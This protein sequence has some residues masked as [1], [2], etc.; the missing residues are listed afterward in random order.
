MHAYTGRFTQLA[1]MA[2]AI[3]EFD[4]K[5]LLHKYLGKLV[6]KN[7]ELDV[8]FHSTPVDEGTDFNALVKCYPWLETE[9][10]APVVDA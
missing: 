9:V 5:E 3:R 7:G 4:G 8:H 2:K 10:S 6:E 1:N